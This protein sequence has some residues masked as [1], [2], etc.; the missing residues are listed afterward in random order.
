MLSLIESGN[1]ND[2]ALVAEQ[3]TM[4]CIPHPQGALVSL[5]ESRNRND[6]ALVAEQGTMCCIPHPRGALVSLIESGNRN[7]STLSAEQGTIC[8]VSHTH[9]ELWCHSQKPGTEMRALYRQN[10]ELY[11]LYPTPTRSSGVVLISFIRRFRMSEQLQVVRT[12]RRKRIGWVK[13]KFNLQ[14]FYILFGSIL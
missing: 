13:F 12:L 5:I 10:R 14:F 7:D 6:S 1:R 11:A 3:G 8:T 9:K 4:C 2:S